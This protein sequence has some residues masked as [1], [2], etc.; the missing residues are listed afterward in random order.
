VP[1]GALF[2]ALAPG[3]SANS[4]RTYFSLIPTHE[5]NGGITYEADPDFLEHL[6]HDIFSSEQGQLL[7]DE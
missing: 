7:W 1:S 5:V 3:A 4:L 6:H 2:A